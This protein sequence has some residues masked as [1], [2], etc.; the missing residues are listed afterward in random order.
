MRLALLLLSWWLGTSAAGGKTVRVAVKAWKQT[1]LL[2]EAAEFFHA[3]DPAAFWAFVD[4]AGE[5]LLRT[6]DQPLSQR[7]LYENAV[8]FSQRTQPPQVTHALKYALSLRHYSPLVAAHYQFTR[9]FLTLHPEVGVSDCFAVMDNASAPIFDAAGLRAALEANPCPASAPTELFDFDHARVPTGSAAPLSSCNVTAVLHCDVASPSFRAFLTILQSQGRPWVLR[10]HLARHFDSCFS[11]PYPTFGEA[12]SD[13]AAEWQSKMAVQGYGVELQIKNMEYKN[14]DERRPS[15]GEAADGD[16]LHT[17]EGEHDATVDT[18][19]DFDVLLRRRPDLT[20]HLMELREIVLQEPETPRPGEDTDDIKVWQIQAIGLQSSSKILRSA[21]PLATLQDIAQNFPKRV[22]AISRLST[23][24]RRYGAV[25]EAISA[26]RD[27]LG[28]AEGSSALYVNGRPQPLDTLT[29]FDLFNT[30]RT[31]GRLLANLNAVLQPLVPSDRSAGALIQELLRCPMSST[32]VPQINPNTGQRTAGALSSRFQFKASVV[33]WMN[34]IEKD[35]DYRSWPAPLGELFKMS[36]FGQVRFPRRN[37]FT[38]IFVIDPTNKEQLSTVPTMRGFLDQGAPTRVGL[39]LICPETLRHVQALQGEEAVE[40]FVADED[41]ERAVMEGT[42]S[43]PTIGQARVTSE[44]AVETAGENGDDSL[45]NEPSAVSEAAEYRPPA[46][47]AAT[48]AGLFGHLYTRDRNGALEFLTRLHSHTK[49][50]VVTAAE[51]EVAWKASAPGPDRSRMH[52]IANG[53]EARD[54]VKKTATYVVDRGMTATPLCLFNGRLMHNRGARDAFFLGMQQEQPF[55]R[56][57]IRDSVLT[58]G[59]KDLYRAILEHTRAQHRYNPQVFTGTAFH[60]TPPSSPLLPHLQYIGPIDPDSV[61]DVTHLIVADV[62]EPTGLGALAQALTHFVNLNPQ[63]SRLA[64][65]HPRS[66]HVS[67]L[68]SLLAAVTLATEGRREQ[69][70]TLLQLVVLLRRVALAR[71]SAALSVPNLEAILAA[72]DHTQR[73]R[74][75]VADDG[76]VYRRRPTLALSFDLDVALDRFKSGKGPPGFAAALEAHAAFA[77]GLPATPAL[78]TNCRAFRLMG[79]SALISDDY[80]L[81]EDFERDQRLDNLTAVLHL[82]GVIPNETFPVDRVRPLADAITLLAGLLAEDSAANGDRTGLATS[83]VD[84]LAGFTVPSKEH[85]KTPGEAPIVTV[86]AV[87]DPL[88]GAAQR[89]APIL[90]SLHSAFHAEIAVHLN[91]VHQLS[92][93]P[94][95]AFYRYV[96]APELQFDP[97]TGTIVPPTAHFTDVTE[98]KVLTMGIEEPEAWIVTPHYAPADLD[99]IRLTDLPGDHL[100]A[101]YALEHIVVTGGCMDVTQGQPPRG[102]ELVMAHAASPADRQDT[103]VMSN[104]GYFQLKGNPGVWRLSL[105]PGSR[106]E[107]IFEIAGSANPAA[108]DTAGGIASPGSTNVVLRGFGGGFVDLKVVRRKGMEEVELL[109]ED[110]SNTPQTPAA[111]TTRSDG[112]WDTVSSYLGKEKEADP[113]PATKP[114]D[115]TLNIFSLASGHLYERL[116]KVMIHT[117]TNHTAHDPEAHVKFW[118]VKNFLSPQFKRFLPLMAEKWG[119]SFELVTYKWPKWLRRQTEK[120]RLIWAYKILF[121]DVLFPLSLDKIIFIDAD[122]IV[123]TDLHALYHMNLQGKALA[124]TPFCDSRSETDGFRFWKQGYWRDHLR[125]LPYHI[126]ALYVVDIK[127]FRQIAAGDNYRML[128]EEL[129][130]DPNSLA[131]LDQDL[132]NYAQ[133]MIRIHSLDLEWLWCETWCSDESKARAKTI[134]LCNNP[135]TKVSKL[136]NARR[137]IPEWDEYD[138]FIHRF[139]ASLNLPDY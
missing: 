25:V 114:G 66:S 80:A 33:A 83:T 64:L 8:A 29:P 12:A 10:H 7:D 86:V 43:T 104:L 138:S 68:P 62:T 85:L 98:S 129:T 30:I 32:P 52:E 67:P 113:R 54:A 35:S 131:N 31:D 128:Y 111:T 82:H 106:G 15:A 71:G 41:L 21:D 73:A 99:N 51:V 70:S 124:Y 58:D 2:H 107:A 61:P 56:E 81:L 118:F 137:I 105:K 20:E 45:A 9:K 46:T 40:G 134:D 17:S 23:T 132:P 94:L 47:L 126:S 34:D 117:V 135:L 112:F 11:D 5:T 139:E 4:V 26:N 50:E 115:P 125:G 37:L 28:V 13:P 122:Q 78:V 90:S 76:N 69:A 92:S 57:L 44:G 65:V 55:V 88:S 48:I 36:F 3:Q 79:E 109:S 75:D 119:F 102:L 116:L 133:Q 136:E 39:V 87:I 91:P 89:L 93:L 60:L 123:R 74:Q 1:S 27:K 53:Q 77:R 121:L 72:M 19:F 42:R 16:V 108:A 49:G 6:G 84:P 100:Y 110:T 96:I 101:E 63:R 24:A 59:T 103:L 95:K 18:G 22:G 130:A 127:K 14:V 97:R 38:I 120:Q